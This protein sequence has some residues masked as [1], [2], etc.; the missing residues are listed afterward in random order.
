MVHD[1]MQ[2]AYRIL[3]P[4][5]FEPDDDDGFLLVGYNRNYEEI[6]RAKIRF[7]RNPHT[8]REV[9][10]PHP[11]ETGAPVYHMYT[12]DP[13]SRKDYWERLGKLFSYSHVVI[14]EKEKTCP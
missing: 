14:D 12:D 3:M 9:W 10:F 5:Y 8:F 6:P 1:S 7:S 11:N 13:D 2:Q 4:Y